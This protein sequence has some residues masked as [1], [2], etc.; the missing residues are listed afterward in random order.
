MDNTRLFELCKILNDKIDAFAY[1]YHLGF[2]NALGDFEIDEDKWEE[3]ETLIEEFE[4]LVA[5]LDCDYCIID[6]ERLSINIFD[7]VETIQGG[8]NG[9]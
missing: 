6:F 5:E 7:L 1:Y 2:Q 4:T 8:N 9:T 3:N